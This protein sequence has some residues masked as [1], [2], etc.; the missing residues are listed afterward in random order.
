MTGYCYFKSANN[1]RCWR[2][3]TKSF[4]SAISKKF[5]KLFPAFLERRD[6]NGQK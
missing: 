1:V 2:L 5:L 4:D 3:E 6:M